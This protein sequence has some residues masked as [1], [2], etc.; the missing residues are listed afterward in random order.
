MPCVCKSPSSWADGGLVID[1]VTKHVKL[2]MR[3]GLWAMHACTASCVLSVLLLVCGR[4]ILLVFRV[5]KTSPTVMLSGLSSIIM[6]HLFL[7]H[8]CTQHE[9]THMHCYMRE[10][11]PG[12][13]RLPSGIQGHHCCRLFRRLCLSIRVR[14]ML[15]ILTGAL[16]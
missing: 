12:W 5:L 14:I 1:V 9:W 16:D 8:L 7:A 2:G 6:Q 3:D 13:P 11:T 10:A 4:D 15:A